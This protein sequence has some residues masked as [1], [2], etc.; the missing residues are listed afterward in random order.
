MRAAVAMRLIDHHKPM[1]RPAIANSADI[2]C[3]FGRVVAIIINEHDLATFAG[4][5]ALHFESAAHALEICDTFLDILIA[6]TFVSAYDNRSRCIQYIMQTRHIDR[7][8]QW[9]CV[10]GALY[11]ET[12]Y[13]LVLFDRTYAEICLLGK[14]ISKD[15]SRH[16]WH[17]FEDYR[18]IRAQH[19]KSVKRQVVQKIDKGLFLR[20][21]NI[22]PGD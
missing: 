9:L 2:G 11:L 1:F 6:E 19:G 10:T 13:A 5:L 3:H 21:F 12:C 20:N 22:A 4:Q 15:W 8:C 18:I 16:P 17:D 7:D 14:T